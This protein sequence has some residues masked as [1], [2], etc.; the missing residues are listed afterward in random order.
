MKTEYEY[1]I[2]IFELNDRSASEIESILN[3]QGE[4]GY[5]VATANE[6]GGFKSVKKVMYTLMRERLKPYDKFPLSKPKFPDL[7]EQTVYRSRANDVLPDSEE[8]P[9]STPDNT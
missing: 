5:M 6:Y 9:F 7:P 1:K 3:Q 4:E 2:L 8:P